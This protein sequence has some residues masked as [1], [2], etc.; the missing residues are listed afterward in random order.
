MTTQ[1]KRL[2][3][4]RWWAVVWRDG[5]PRWVCAT[6]DQA[7]AFRRGTLSP[8]ETRLAKCWLVEE[9]LYRVPK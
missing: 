8:R 6:R 3:P 2:R 7:R 4:Q 9:V 5:T 1:W